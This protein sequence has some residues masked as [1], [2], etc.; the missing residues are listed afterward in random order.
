MSLANIEKDIINAINIEKE[1]SLLHLSDTDLELLRVTPDQSSSQKTCIRYFLIS[2]LLS[3]RGALNQDYE[4]SIRLVDTAIIHVGIVVSAFKLHYRSLGDRLCEFCA[5]FLHLNNSTTTHLC[6]NLPK[7]VPLLRYPVNDLNWFPDELFE[8]FQLHITATSPSPLIF[9][10]LA[11]SWP[12]CKAWNNTQYLLKTMANGYRCVPV[13]AGRKYTDQD[14]GVKIIPFNRFLD[15]TL[16]PRSSRE[17]RHYYLAQHN[18]FDQIPALRADISVPDICNVYAPELDYSATEGTNCVYQPV[19]DFITPII[20]VWIGP[21]QTVSPLHRD[22]HNNIYTQVVGYKYFRLH[23]PA[24]EDTDA[25]PRSMY[26]NKE[27]PSTSMIDLFDVSTEN[28]TKYP[29]FDWHG[30]YFEAIL[31]PGDALFI[32]FGWWH[33]VQS[34]SNSIGVNF[35]F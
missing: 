4:K 3:A 26:I 30:R 6:V 33:Y 15:H 18:L 19:P 2:C 16:K 17:D 31:G 1:D 13:E 20:N 11:H 7:S 27:M 24:T 23:P 28:Q 34:L 9:R 5:Q 14:W 12:A 35:W 32:P 8:K 21:A 25:K 29:N 10:G 22:E